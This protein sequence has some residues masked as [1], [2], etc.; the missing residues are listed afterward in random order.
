MRLNDLINLAV[1]ARYLYNDPKLA[2]QY[3]IVHA[4][5]LI[6]SGVN[7]N[8]A[9]SKTAKSFSSLAKIRGHVLR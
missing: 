4:Q 6:K 5:R 8:E 3:M 2:N 1:D 7:Q 9:Y